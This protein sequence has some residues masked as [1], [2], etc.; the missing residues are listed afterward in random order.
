MVGLTGR[1][2]VNLEVTEL[3]VIKLVMRV[4]MVDRNRNEYIR[5][6]PVDIEDSI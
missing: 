6:L 4:I 5:V 2:K 3:R 1:Q